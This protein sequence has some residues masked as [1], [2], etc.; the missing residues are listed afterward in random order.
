MLFSHSPIRMCSA[1][2]AGS[3]GGHW[4]DRL[5]KQVKLIIVIAI[6]SILLLLFISHDSS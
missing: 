3:G 2:S 6:T 4:G 5:Q 1:E